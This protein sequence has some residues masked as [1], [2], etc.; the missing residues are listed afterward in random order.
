MTKR[1]K[2]DAPSW[3]LSKKSRETG[4]DSKA[5]SSRSTVAPNI[6]FTGIRNTPMFGSYSRPRNRSLSTAVIP[7][8]LSIRA[9]T[10]IS[11]CFRVYEN[12]KPAKVRTL[13]EVERN[14]ASRRRT[15]FSFPGN[16]GHTDRLDT[17]AELEYLRDVAYPHTLQRLYRSEVLLTAYS[18]AC[19]RRTPAAPAM[20]YS[21][22]RN[23]R[24]AR[25]GPAGRTADTRD[26][27]SIAPGRAPPPFQPLLPITPSPTALR[28]LG[29]HCSGIRRSSPPHTRDYEMLERAVRFQQP[30][31]FNYRA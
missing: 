31:C 23:S 29:S 3:L 28:R 8:I 4:P 19:A 5:R 22:T 6:T 25:D 24:K 13:P 30:S 18:A 17:V 16:P 26:H 10:S 7:T 9:T 1:S 15:R 21:A 27:G 11:V 14:G 12:G 2:P 20:I